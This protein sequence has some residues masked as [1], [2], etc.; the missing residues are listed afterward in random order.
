[1]KYAA[2]YVRP[3]FIQALLEISERTRSR[4]GKGRAGVVSLLTRQVLERKLFRM[5]MKRAYAGIKL[6]WRLRAVPKVKIRFRCGA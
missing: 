2:L 1:L 4:P 3:E 6:P 5:A